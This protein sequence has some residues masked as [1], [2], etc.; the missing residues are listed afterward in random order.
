MVN[1][2]LIY[3]G[4]VRVFL[5]WLD[6]FPHDFDLDTDCG[7]LKQIKIFAKNDL[8]ENLGKELLKRVQQLLDKVTITPFDVMGMCV[9]V[10]LLTIVKLNLIGSVFLYIVYYGNANFNAYT[11]H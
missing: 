9:C 7:L 10:N 2:S 6:H 1:Y 8:N 3:R 11:S 5:V 4:T